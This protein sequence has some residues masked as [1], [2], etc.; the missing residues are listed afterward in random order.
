MLADRLRQD[1]LEPLLR[2]FVDRGD[3]AAIQEFVAWT[4]PRLHSVARKI[5]DASEAHDVVQEA[6]LSMLRKGSAD[7]GAPIMGWLITAVVRIAYHRKAATNRQAEVLERLARP[8]DDDVRPVDGMA[9]AEEARI[10]QEEVHR[11]PPAYRDVLVLH[12][13]HELTTSRIAELLGTPV[14]TVKTRLQRGRSLLQPRLA[15]RIALGICGFLLVCGDRARAAAGFFTPVAKAG[16]ATKVALGSVLAAA[17]ALAL[18]VVWGGGNEAPARSARPGSAEGGNALSVAEQPQPADPGLPPAADTVAND[19]A[20]PPASVPPPSSALEAAARFLSVSAEAIAAAADA[21]AKLARGNRMLVPQHRREAEEALDRLRAFRDGGEAYRAVVALIRARRS[22]PWF[23]ELA[24]ATWVPDLG[25]EDLLIAAG[26]GARPKGPTIQAVVL[27][28][29]AADTPRSRD[30]LIQVL[31]E[32]P[33][34]MAA[35][36]AARALGRWGERRAVPA[37]AAWLRKP[38]AELARW[39]L[40]GSLGGM[41]GPEAIAVLQDYVR[42]GSP[43]EMGYALSALVKADR[44]LARAEVAWALRVRAADFA[45]LPADAVARFEQLARE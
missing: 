10:V 15:S 38:E 1:E 8:R 41:G 24:A 34:G 6:Y 22:G 17:G 37:V 32:T 35:V 14:A 2:R 13:M 21:E 28:L 23:E 25:L 3:S 16:T 20:Q 7:L 40:L 19:T 27:A 11:L 44:P 18:A 36:Y 42:N 30:Y 26:K 12:Y 45:R 43:E 4:R 33:D 5:V 39:Q 29:G 31:T 9:R